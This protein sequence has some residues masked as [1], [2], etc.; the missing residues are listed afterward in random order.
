MEFI[1]YE[2]DGKTYKVY[3]PVAMRLYKGGPEAMLRGK[4]S[5]GDAPS[6]G[7]HGLSRLL[8]WPTILLSVKN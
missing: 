5:M 6:F 7:P 8:L 1:R 2:D 3:D 4:T